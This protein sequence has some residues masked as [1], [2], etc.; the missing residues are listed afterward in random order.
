MKSIER[1]GKTAWNTNQ[2]N[3]A[4][5][6]MH[7]LAE[8]VLSSYA[9]LISVLASSI[10]ICLCY[11]RSSTTF[12]IISPFPY[13]SSFFVLVF[14]S[15][16]SSYVARSLLLSTTISTY[17]SFPAGY[18]IF[19]VICIME[20]G[21]LFRLFF[22]L[23]LAWS[24]QIHLEHYSRRWHPSPSFS[25]SCF[26]AMFSTPTSLF[27]GNTDEQQ[28]KKGAAKMTCCI[29]FNHQIDFLSAYQCR[30]GTWECR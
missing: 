16:S 20:T 27:A 25:P 10:F 28:N 6:S 5:V 19:K 22:F 21:L 4:C 30:H 23:G 7:F 2:S 8:I 12:I 24:R 9:Q 3:F 13:L 14:S 11:Y 26:V 18:L 29:P 15:F 17:I 1:A